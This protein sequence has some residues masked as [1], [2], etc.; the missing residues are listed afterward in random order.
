M[1]WR[2][3]RNTLPS[4]AGSE[5]SAY[6]GVAGATDWLLGARSTTSRANNRDWGTP[7]PNETLDG[8]KDDSE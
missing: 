8:G 5:R 4:L 1:L 6:E 3:V 7:G 2:M